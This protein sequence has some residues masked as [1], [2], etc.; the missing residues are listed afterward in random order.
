MNGYFKDYKSTF[1]QAMIYSESQGLNDTHFVYNPSIAFN[2]RDKRQIAMSIVQFLYKEQCYTLESLVG[3]CMTMSREVQQMLKLRFGLESIVTT[4]TGYDSVVNQTIFD[5]SRDKLEA[6][7]RKD[8]NEDFYAHAWLTL[9]NL[10][11]LD[12]TLLPSLWTVNNPG[13]ANREQYQG[14]IWTSSSPD[15]GEQ[16]SYKPLI[17]GYDYYQKIDLPIK[18]IEF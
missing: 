8:Y 3:L 12:V 6:R 4:G 1:N 10:D 11:I 14:L 5:E 7:M 13:G 15:Q 17:I 9:P 16:F 18:K 2:S